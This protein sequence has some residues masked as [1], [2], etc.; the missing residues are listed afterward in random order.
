MKN[1]AWVITAGCVFQS[2]GYVYGLPAGV[3][4]PGWSPHEQFHLILGTFWLA[5]LNLVLVALAWGP[6]QRRERWAFWLLLLGLLTAHGGHFIA[7]LM[8]PDGRHPEWWYDLALGLDGL[9]YAVGLGLAWL[10]YRRQ[11][12]PVHQTREGSSAAM[13]NAA[14]YIVGG[15]L[16]QIGGYA[17]ALPE[18]LGD[19]TWSSHA[20][21]HHIL[22]WLW[23]VGLNIAL[24]TLAWLPM[25][26][27]ERWTLW[28]L[29][30]GLVFGQTAHFIVSA[31]YPAGRWAGWEWWFD[32]A[33]AL[34]ALIYA[35]GLFM[36]RE[37]MPHPG[38][39]AGFRHA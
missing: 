18:H 26:R 11:G 1:A 14:L 24:M 21:F 34:Q 33:L 7:S 39:R 5:G 29:L 23:Q 36:A 13:G 38:A 20:Q 6:L 35:A 16:I 22:A 12:S 19:P 27:G 30:A 31:L 17:Y 32:W 2:L 37:A 4:Q 8:V 10:A 3:G 25:R 28:P 15:C 9:I